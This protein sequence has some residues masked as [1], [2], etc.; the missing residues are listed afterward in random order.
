MRR[1]P[2]TRRGFMAGVAASAFAAPAI[3]APPKARPNILLVTTDDQGIQAGCYGDAVVRTPGIDRLAEEGVRFQ[4]AYV[5]H[6]SCSPSRSS[7]FTGRYP[8]QNGQIGLSHY[9]YRTRPGV[10]MLPT[11]L[12]R[13]G[14]RTGVIGKVHVAPLDA[15]RF[16]YA[17]RDALST[18]DVGTV[19]RKAGAFI[20]D[21]GDTPFFLMV[22]YFDPHRPYEAAQLEG[23][24]ADPHQP[25]RTRPFPFLGVDT[26]AVREEVAG[27]YNA[28]ERADAGLGLLLDA[29]GKAGKLDD[30]IVVFLGDHGPPF[31]RA[32]TTC[33]EAG[34]RI[35]L[36]VR[37]PGGAEA[38]VMREEG[39]STVDLMPTLLEAAGV[40]VPEGLA[41]R[42]L[43][44]LLRGESV[45]WREAVATEYTSHALGHFFPRRAIRTPRWKLI[46]NLLPGFGTPLWTVGVAQADAA[47]AGSLARR[48]YETY[49]QPPEFELYDLAL[50]PHEFRNLADSASHAGMLQRMRERLRAWQRESDDPLRDPDA[51]QRLADRHRDVVRQGPGAL[52][53]PGEEAG[54]RE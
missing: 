20:D 53:T 19:A 42:S 38:G 15:F 46:H 54:F 35:P 21:A 47:P 16:D 24:P 48:A 4:Q 33:Y 31:T 40:A 37:W 45:P 25:E 29:L 52:W 13:A 14:Y 30:T 9:G 3:G 6:A 12:H 50:D 43:A 27:Y 28:V 23:I 1:R 36:L 11:A 44:P 32:K 8:H 22:N 34:V 10:E 2:I 41:G 5:T 39:V 49:M 18:Q 26:P 51:L 7:I 17:D